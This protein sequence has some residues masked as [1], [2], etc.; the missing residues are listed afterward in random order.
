[1]LRADRRTTWLLAGLFVLTG[2]SGLIFETLWIRLLAL[3]FGQTTTAMAT[4]VAAYMAGLAFG[5]ILLGRLADRVSS[6]LRIYG[7]MEVGIGI[8]ALLIPLASKLITAIYIKLYFLTGG[9]A[10]GTQI[11]RIVLT[12]LL[13]LVPT[14]LMGGTLP[15]LVRALTSSRRDMTR[16]P[17]LFYAANTAGGVAGLLLAGF[18]MIEAFGQRATNTAAALFN[19]AV[20]FTCLLL[21]RRPSPVT[22]DD[23]KPSA[24]PETRRPL[25][26]AQ[27]LLALAYLLSGLLALVYE[28]AW[29]K[30]FCL[31]FD[32]TVHAFSLILAVYIGG[33]AV[34]G[35]IAS[36]LLSRTGDPIYWLG[37][38]IALV[39]VA[40][41]IGLPVYDRCAQY[42]F[43]AEFMRQAFGTSWFQYLLTQALI[44]VAVI[45]VP[46]TLIGA[47]F[48]AAVAAWSRNPE[49]AGSEI[50]FMAG[51]GSLGAVLG[52]LLA[53]FVLIPFLGNQNT[54]VA[55]GYASILL[56]LSVILLLR[57]APASRLLKAAI[58]PAALALGATLVVLLVPP[59]KLAGFEEQD[60]VFRR[61]GK[62][63]TVEVYKDPVTG[64]QEMISNRRRREGGDLPDDVRTHRFLAYLPGLLHPAPERVA[65]LGMGTG[66][67]AGALLDFQPEQLVV[68]E[69]SPEIIEAAQTCFATS[70][71]D[72][73]NRRDGPARVVQA[74]ARN[75]LLLSTE[76]FDLIVGDLFN[77][78]RAGVGNLYTFE[79]FQMVKSRLE[80]AGIFC[81]WIALNQIS[82]DNLRLVLRTFTA[83]FPHTSLFQFGPYLALIATPESLSIDLFAY[84]AR[85][86]NAQLSQNILASGLG[87]PE[88]HLARFL[89]ADEAVQRFAGE[90]KFNVDNRPL[91]EY[92]A[93][94]DF[95]DPVGL[96]RAADTLEAFLPLKQPVGERIKIANNAD[97]RLFMRRLK[98]CA[99]AMTLSQQGQVATY[100]GNRQEAARK[101]SEAFYLYPQEVYA[102]RNH[103][104]SFLELGRR[105]LIAGLE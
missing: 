75:Y 20:G 45:F 67:T 12:W 92:R 86:D 41:L 37:M 72:I 60:V 40:A 9:S 8:I 26:P 58:V 85:F 25:I 18:V 3:S 74:D 10:V 93:P 94:K 80:P 103:A 59:S 44:A 23:Q 7:F 99:R 64:Y 13:L 31:V 32:N 71:K 29:I 22:A 96:A 63:S 98:A 5:A 21:A 56:G 77:P 38:L 88:Q 104:R 66:V 4:V 46:A 30:S 90:G 1:M 79:H 91:I 14:F 2:A 97:H 101:F 81:Q 28:I 89:F 36:R 17:G 100:R 24:P 52:P 76:T 35:F 47:S 39:G 34:G 57:K 16:I 50:G 55:A 61:E 102:R 62:S 6:P 42:F 19:L 48:P 53:G 70:N 87:T 68:A 69:L 82:T 15:T 95:H 11:V 51:A 65:V 78:N 49:K 83:V 73:A 27:R 105:H 84:L 54:L 43:D 33:L